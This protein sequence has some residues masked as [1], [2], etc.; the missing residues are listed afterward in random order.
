MNRFR[1]DPKIKR[2]C[3]GYQDQGII[4][5]Q[6]KK[7]QLRSRVVN[8]KFNTFNAIILAVVPIVSI[9]GIRSRPVTLTSIS[10]LVVKVCPLINS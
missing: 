4:G 6:H 9:A 2:A 7:S 10:I 8:N 1:I 3:N 5:I